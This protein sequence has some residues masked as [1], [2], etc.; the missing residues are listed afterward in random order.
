MSE[1]NELTLAGFVAREA[2]RTPEAPAGSVDG[3]VGREP[4]TYG[5]LW[6]KGR[7]LAA[8]LS[9]L[10]IVAGDR[11]ALMLAGELELADAM[12]ACSVIGA[13]FVSL[14]P[15]VDATELAHTL[16]A[17]GCKGVIAPDYALLPVAVVRERI[18]TL[19]WVVGICTEQGRST[20][21]QLQARGVRPYAEVAAAD[22]SARTFA[23]SNPDDAMQLVFPGAAE[24]S[25]PDIVTHRQHFE[26]TMAMPTSSD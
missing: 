13:V 2:R 25:L 7:R 26:T 11:I 6:D 10:G 8:G 21:A 17:C 1:Y 23:G 16:Q 18:Y 12:V 19:R 22:A 4:R 24:H 14:D 15:R 3:A 5:L 9:K 20:P